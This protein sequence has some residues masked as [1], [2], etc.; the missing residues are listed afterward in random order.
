M[1]NVVSRSLCSRLDRVALDRERVGSRVGGCRV[2]HGRTM[3]ADRAFRIDFDL[4]AW[5]TVGIFS[6]GV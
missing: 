6:R 4:T 5:E 1:K 3:L 2:D